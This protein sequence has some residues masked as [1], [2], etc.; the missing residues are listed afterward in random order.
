MTKKQLE[1]YIKEIRP[2]ADAYDRIC[3]T[4]GIKN[5]ILGY[6]DKIKANP[7]DLQV[8]LP[9]IS[10]DDGAIRFEF[11]DGGTNL[12]WEDLFVGQRY[13]NFQAEI[14]RNIHKAYIEVLNARS[15]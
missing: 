6:I 13:P 10:I 4:L 8:S 1:N 3:E 9:S 2:K 12:F 11:K 5:D 14:M 15:N 7:V